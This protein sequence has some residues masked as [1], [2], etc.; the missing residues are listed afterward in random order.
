MDASEVQIPHPSDTNVDDSS[1]GGFA[2]TTN[3]EVLSVIVG[4]FGRCLRTVKVHWPLKTVK[5]VHFAIFVGDQAPRS[6]EKDEALP[7]RP[8]RATEPRQARP[9]AANEPSRLRKGGSL[10]F[11]FSIGAYEKFSGDT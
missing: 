7:S 1:V 4:R 5:V 2:I 9:T 6:S 3:A 10:R 11:Y 8:S